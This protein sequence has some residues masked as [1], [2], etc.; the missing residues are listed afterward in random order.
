M[1]QKKGL[2]VLKL[3]GT[4]WTSLCKVG[5][6]KCLGVVEKP[7][8]GT[9]GQQLR[10]ALVGPGSRSD[11]LPLSSPPRT[12]PKPLQQVLSWWPEVALRLDWDGLT[13]ARVLA[14]FKLAVQFACVS[15]LSGSQHD[16]LHGRGGPGAGVHAP[17]PIILACK[18]PGQDKQAFKSILDHTGGRRPAWTA[19]DSIS[20]KKIMCV[21]VFP[22][23]F[24]YLDFVLLALVHG[25][26]GSVTV[27]K[28]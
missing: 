21:L 5:K 6:L 11:G 18:G 15:F 2:R 17:V 28:S 19:C 23:W 7:C 16:H 24:S 26:A 25:F 8:V 22:S 9:D 3:G 20:K 1:K 12:D 13:N 10:K 27:G 4:E 14:L